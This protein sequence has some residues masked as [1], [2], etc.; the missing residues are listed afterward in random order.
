V[1]LLSFLNVV[2][3]IRCPPK[4]KYEGRYNGEEVN[5]FLMLSTIERNNKPPIIKVRENDVIE[6][7]EY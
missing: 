7:V 1:Y 3:S 4:K 2:D 6:K 5:S